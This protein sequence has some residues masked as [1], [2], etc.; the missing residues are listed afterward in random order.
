MLRD[1][2]IQRLVDGAIRISE[3]DVAGPTYGTTARM[4]S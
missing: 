4:L 2:Q 1:A 3:L